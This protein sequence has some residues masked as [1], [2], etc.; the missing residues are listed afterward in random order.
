M[1]F[2][3]FV[4]LHECCIQAS[5]IVSFEDALNFC[6]DQRNVLLSASSNY[7]AHNEVLFLLNLLCLLLYLCLS[8]VKF[9]FQAF[10]L[11]FHVL[12]VHIR[13]DFMVLLL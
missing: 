8:H 7:C 1:S 13:L 5:H 2:L 9:S 12:A 3:Q 6:Y 10:N 11:V 4:N